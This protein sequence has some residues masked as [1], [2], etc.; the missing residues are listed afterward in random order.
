MPERTAVIASTSG[1]HARPAT[2]F[3]EAAAEYEDLEIMIRR[4]GDPADEG[5]D[6]TS[7]LSLMSL[8]LEHGDHVVLRSNDAGSEQALQHLV[9]LLETNHDA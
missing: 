4:A 9:E 5:M 6:A 2:V 1:L 8:G 3:V 7:V